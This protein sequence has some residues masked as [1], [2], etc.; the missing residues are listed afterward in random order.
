MVK[1]ASVDELDAQILDEELG[2][3]LK[4]ELMLIF[5]LV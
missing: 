1:V 2:Q 5:P 3:L 4:K